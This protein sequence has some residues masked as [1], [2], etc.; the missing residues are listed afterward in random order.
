MSQC[1]HGWVLLVK[2]GEDGVRR[3]VDG[4]EKKMYVKGARDMAGTEVYAETV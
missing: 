3:Q 4:R 1:T 2:A